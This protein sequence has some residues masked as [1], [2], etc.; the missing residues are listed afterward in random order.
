MDFNCKFELM[1]S[2]MSAENKDCL[3]MGDLNCN[4]LENADNKELKSL[5][6]SFGLKQLVER[7]TRITKESKTFIDIICSTDPLDLCSVKVI[8]AG[9]NVHEL[10]GCIRK[11][12]NVKYHPRVISCRNY[13]NYNQQ[14]FL[15]DLSS[16]SFEQI[17]TTSCVNKACESLQNILMQCIDKHVPCITKKVKGRSC[18]WLTSDVKREMNVRDQ[19]LRKARRT[20]R[21]VDWSSYKCQR[22]R[23]TGLVKKCK[24]NYYRQLLNDSAGSPDKFWSTIKKL[25]PTKKT[26]QLGSALRINDSL[27]TDENHIA[28]E[29]CAYFTNSGATSKAKSFQICDS[30]WRRFVFE[31]IPYAKNKFCFRAVTE[32]EILKELKKLN[33]RKATGLDNLP[34]GQWRI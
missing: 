20:N 2:S 23:V 21:E 16:N 17:Y 6:V 22:N 4:Y 33:R 27:I 19:F 18:P 28:N 24:S 31:T 1:L 10:I 13:A 7:P 3:L 5:L 9:L 25:Y 12:N 15:N 29:F 8:P 26:T 32:L 30:I 34:S 11:L 14:L